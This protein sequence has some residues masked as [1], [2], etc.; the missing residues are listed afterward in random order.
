[1]AIRPEKISL[2]QFSPE[3]ESESVIIQGVVAEKVYVGNN[4]KYLFK[5]GNKTNLKVLVQNRADQEDYSI[6]DRLDLSWFKD[7]MVF[8]DR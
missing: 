8:L 6:G 7:D 4:T 2:M 5:I 3:N 1:M